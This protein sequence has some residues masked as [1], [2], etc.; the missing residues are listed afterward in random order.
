MSWEEIV[1]TLESENMSIAYLT[2]AEKI[3]R[4]EYILQNEEHEWLN[5]K[6]K[7]IRNFRP[8][9]PESYFSSHVDNTYVKCK[10]FT[11]Q[12]IVD[13]VHLHLFES[14]ENYLINKNYPT[15]EFNKITSLQMRQQRLLADGPSVWKQKWDMLQNLSREFK[16]QWGNKY[17]LS[18]LHA[19]GL[20]LAVQDT[21][22][23]INLIVNDKEG[24]KNYA[25]WI[26]AVLL[27][28][29]LYF[30]YIFYNCLLYIYFI[31]IFL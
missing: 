18:R 19:G 15:N 30:I 31:Y 27:F 22:A 1:R 9:N 5:K 7:E 8:E 25:S 23:D 11:F 20:M 6:L 24:M 14:Y 29:K 4:I 16:C 26:P 10:R 2:N 28:L 13:A 3:I 17:D 12:N 21:K